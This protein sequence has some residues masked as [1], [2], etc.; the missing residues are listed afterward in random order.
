MEWVDLGSLRRVHPRGTNRAP[1][2]FAR[3]SGND[4]PSD[5]SQSETGT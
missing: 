5:R 2:V 1:T 4:P 3:N